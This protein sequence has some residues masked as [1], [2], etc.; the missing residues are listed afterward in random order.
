[1]NRGRMLKTILMCAC[2]FASAVTISG[3]QSLRTADDGRVRSVICLYENDAWLNLDRAGDLDPE[4]VTYKVY[5]KTGDTTSVLRD[6]IF[7]I[8]IYEVDRDKEGNATRTLHADYHYPTS[9][10]HRI[11]KMGLMGPGYQVALLFHNKNVVG[12][13]IDI[14]TIYEAPD[15]YE[16][17]SQTRRLKVPRIEE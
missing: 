14:V 8:S 9:D 2:A 11:K 10:I 1:M 7:H 13:E 15:G 4:G 17:R 5:L 12:K 3:C 6:G 16:I